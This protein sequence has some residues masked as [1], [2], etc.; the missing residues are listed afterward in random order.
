MRVYVNTDSWIILDSPVSSAA[1][2]AIEF[3]RGDSRKLEIYFVSPDPVAP[4]YHDVTCTIRAAIRP[5][6]WRASGSWQIG[7]QVIPA[8][9]TTSQVQAAFRAHTGD[10][11]LI[12]SGSMAEGYTV[13]WSV[14]GSQS[15]LD[16]IVSDLLPECVTVVDRRR[17]GNASVSEIQSILFQPA[18]AAY[19]DVFLP[20]SETVT[21]NVTST[22]GNSTQDERQ[23]IEFSTIPV[24]GQW[25]LTLPSY[26]IDCVSVANGV[27]TTP[28]HHGF[29]VGQKVRLEAFS[30]P[31]NF[32]NGQEYY[33]VSVPTRTTFRI[34]E[35]HNG[36]PINA[37][38]TAGTGYITSLNATTA[39]LRYNATASEV[40]ETLRALA[41]IGPNGVYVSGAMPRYEIIFGGA[42]GRVNLPSLSVMTQH[43]RASP[44]YEGE[45]LFSS[46]ALRDYMGDAFSLDGV[47]EL[48]LSLSG[49]VIT[50]QCKAV[51]LADVLDTATPPPSSM[52]GV[53]TM[54]KWMP[55]ITAL[56]GGG[57]TA[58][59]GLPTI[60]LPLGTLVALRISGVPHWYVLDAG[61]SVED[62]PAIIRPDDF[63][64]TTNPKIWTRYL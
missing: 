37:S 17:A 4:K 62:V 8:D 39:A 1:R 11:G 60:H 23:V 63:D 13:R 28:T 43:L 15:L 64:A 31:T 12:V 44:R 46:Y 47:F 24:S 58:L 26:D 53:V 59:D 30:S 41:E 56:T 40:Q 34:S 19:Q 55:A 7:S 49:Q 32:A 9:A 48:E 52:T 27:F 33:I 45:L 35:N 14:T 57:D 20:L 3:F 54:P 50:S 36:T 2:T 18:P 51:I 22:D 10:S 61:T 6:K 42:K 5:L 21:A 29:V 38:A 16:P 25:T